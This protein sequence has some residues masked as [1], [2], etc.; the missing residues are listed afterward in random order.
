[1]PKQENIFPLIA[2][3]L[4]GLEEILAAELLALGAQRIETG[5][6]MVRFYGDDGFMYKAN[7]CLRTALR[8]L[9]PI[10]EFKVR[11]EK[12][13]YRKLYEIEWEK[14]LSD[15]RTFAVDAVVSGRI[16]RNSHY[17]QLRTKDAIV[18]R[19]R[20][21]SGSRPDVAKSDPDVQFHVHINREKV[22]VSLD[23]SGEP[24]FKRGYKAGAVKAPINEV[25]AAGLLLLAGWEGGSHLIDPMC[26]SGTFLIE[27][28]MI[29]LN[30]PPQVRRESFGFESWPDFDSA[31]FD[32]IRTGREKQMRD[33]PYSFVGY[34]TNYGAFKSAKESVH[35]AGLEDFISIYQKDFFKSYPPDGPVTL[36]FNPPYGERLHHADDFYRK[37]GDTLKQQYAGATAWLITSD[38]A[39]LK[40]VGLKTSRRINI[41][42]GA[43]ECKFVRYDLYSGSKKSGKQGSGENEAH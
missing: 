7:F 37:I 8:I 29:A 18:D 1:M 36:V 15:N 14:L 32:L 27:G 28:A 10:S 40:N 39:A 31:L 17:I 6:R 24:L 35:I 34:D 3:T 12:E 16:F 43:L 26:G 11:N 20:D 23:S 21:K 2:K 9:K 25:L 13:L 38:I 19:L 41:R 5:V 4:P 42:N 30:I 33:M 22:S